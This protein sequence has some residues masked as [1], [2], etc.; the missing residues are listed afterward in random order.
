MSKCW[1]VILKVRFIS[2]SLFSVIHDPRKH[3]LS[4]KTMVSQNVPKNCRY[5]NCHLVSVVA[6]RNESERR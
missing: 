4:Q 2:G 1:L 5:R 6:L 3:V